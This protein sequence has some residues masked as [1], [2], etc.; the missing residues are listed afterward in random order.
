MALG[1]AG[2]ISY[3]V[4]ERRRELGIRTALGAARWQLMKMVLR[5]TAFVAGSGVAMGIVLGITAT[6][7]LRSQFYGI[8]TVEWSVLIPV[9]AV[10]LAVS[11]AVAY[12]SAQPWITVDPMEAVRH[13]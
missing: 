9:A 10:M 4:S 1:L 6:T 5:Q 8:R 12:L 3:S 2:A 7:L 11:L 13:A